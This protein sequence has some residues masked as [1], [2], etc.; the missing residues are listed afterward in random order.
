MKTKKVHKQF[1]QPL[2]KK[3][4]AAAVKEAKGAKGAKKAAKAKA[5]E[6]AVVVVPAGAEAKRAVQARA[7]L[8]P[9]VGAVV[10]RKRIGLV[11][12]AISLVTVIEKSAQMVRLTIHLKKSQARAKSHRREATLLAHL[13]EAGRDLGGWLKRAPL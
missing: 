11:S 12:S 1:Q 4:K 6:A 8:A 3:G 10:T 2:S 9:Q 5:I 13:E 7:V